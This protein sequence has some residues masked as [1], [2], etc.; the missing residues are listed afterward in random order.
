MWSKDLF[1]SVL[2]QVCG[3]AQM[4]CRNA[5]LGNTMTQFAPGAGQRLMFLHTNLSPKWSLNLPGSFKDYTR[6]WQVLP[7]SC[8]LTLASL[9]RGLLQAPDCPACHRSTPRR[10]LSDASP[11]QG[12]HL[13][14]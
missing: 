11:G 10:E 3:V 9:A 8:A 4:H 14:P 13:G 7:C 12:C 2:V 6:R 5:F 1:V